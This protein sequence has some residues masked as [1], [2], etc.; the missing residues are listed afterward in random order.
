[1]SRYRPPL[2]DTDQRPFSRSMGP[3]PERGGRMFRPPLGSRPPWSDR[4]PHHRPPHHRPSHQRP[5]PERPP[6]LRPPH[7]RPPPAHNWPSESNWSSESGWPQHPPGPPDWSRPPPPMPPVSAADGALGVLSS[8]GLDAG[9]L[10]ALAELPE[11]ML[12]LKSLPMLLKQIKG[13]KKEPR[14]QPYLPPAGPAPRQDME[15]SLSFHREP[16]PSKS[17]FPAA[18]GG[19]SFVVEYGHCAASVDESRKSP[20]RSRRPSPGFTHGSKDFRRSSERTP[21]SGATLPTETEARDFLGKRPLGFPHSCS[22]CDITVLSDLVWTQHVKST[23][24]ADSQVLLMKRYPTW[25]CRMS[26]IRKRSE[27]VVEA[28]KKKNKKEGPSTKPTATI[29]CAKFPSHSIDAAHIRYLL[30]DFGD[31]V[32]VAMFPTLAFVELQTPEQAQ[33]VVDHFTKAPHK[34]K[35][36]NV[37][38][39]LST[40]FNFLQ[41]SFVLNFHPVP[42]GMDG[43]TD[44]LSIIKRFGTPRYTM[45][46]PKRM[47][48]YVEMMDPAEAHKLME[49][50]AESPLKMNGVD[51]KVTFSQEF[52]TLARCLKAVAYGKDG[53]P[54]SSQSSK[55]RSSPS[56]EQGSKPVKSEAKSP[57]KPVDKPT[58]SSA[59]GGDAK[60]TTESEAQPTETKPTDAGPEPKEDSVNLSEDNTEEV[61]MQLD[62][63]VVPMEP[64]NESD[65]PFDLKYCITLDEVQPGAEE[66]DEDDDEEDSPRVVY[67]GNLPLCQ[68]SDPQ[69]L[70]MVMLV[71]RPVR[72]F[73]NRRERRALVEFK[74][75]FAARRFVAKMQNHDFGGSPIDSFIS[76]KYNRLPWGRGVEYDDYGRIMR[77]FRIGTSPPRDG[78]PKPV[79]RLSHRFAPIEI[80]RSSRSRSRGRVRGRSRSRSRERSRGRWGRSPDRFRRS[81]RDRSQGKSR[82]RTKGGSRDRSRDRSQGRSRGRSRDKSKAMSKGRSM[83]RQSPRQTEKS[84]ETDQMGS[85]NESQSSQSR[86]GEGQAAKDAPA[87]DAQTKDAQAKDAQ[88][89]DA[90]AKEVPADHAPAKDAPPD[91]VAE[92]GPKAEEEGWVVHED[93][94]DQRQE[95]NV[96]LQI[97]SV[98]SLKDDPKEE[99]AVKDGG[100]T[101]EGEEPRD[102]QDAMATEAGAAEIAVPRKPIGMEFILFYCDLCDVKFSD[103][104]DARETHCSSPQH[105]LKYQERTRGTTD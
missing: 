52:R 53:E 45:F 2:A 70:K 62:E 78:V 8:Y 33:F 73:L 29:V 76:N 92:D 95:K 102:K 42:F 96:M 23:F 13:L 27:N 9:D 105:C 59:S 65:C 90:Q 12:T 11:D 56:K 67:I 74:S 72:Y 68:F 4:P 28:P 104:K 81:S 54:I 98:V 75:Q 5:P 99:G 91:A 60:P 101:E 43:Q 7:L 16:V 1:M 51:I 44:L 22:I 82:D 10:S 37:E 20:E 41:S 14:A 83:D 3:G 77:H 85:K 69:F 19:S 57:E 32:T 6:H 71:S 93:M 86:D 48:A 15:H 30:D 24:H 26:S 88:T 55:K 84:G 100:D 34:V 103:E 61:A 80:R 58:E 79:N 38:F 47:Q 66:E 21:V 17:D 97:L 94:D 35:N 63:E 46:L 89:K 36:E 31:I 18:P 39:T 40:T 87:E 25:D 50:Y 64:E 49:Y